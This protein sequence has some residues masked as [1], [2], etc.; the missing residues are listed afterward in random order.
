MH[1]QPKLSQIHWTW[2]AKKTLLNAGA[3]HKN[4]SEAV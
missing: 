3:A 4:K 2:K 1:T